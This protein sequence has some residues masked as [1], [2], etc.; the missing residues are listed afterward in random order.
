MSLAQVCL[1]GLAELGSLGSHLGKVWINSMH[2]HQSQ[3]PHS[4][5]HLSSFINLYLLIA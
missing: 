5:H 3:S 1:G 4:H 2:V